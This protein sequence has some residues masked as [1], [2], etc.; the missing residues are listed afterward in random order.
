MRSMATWFGNESE[1]LTWFVDSSNVYKAK[2]PFNFECPMTPFQ[3][4]KQPSTDDF[5]GLQLTSSPTMDHKTEDF[6][7]MDQPGD[8]MDNPYV[9]DSLEDEF[10]RFSVTP[11]A[12]M[13]AIMLKQSR[14][15]GSPLTPPNSV[16]SHRKIHERDPKKIMQSSSIITA[17]SASSCPSNYGSAVNTPVLQEARHPAQDQILS[18]NFH[19]RDTLRKVELNNL[20]HAPVP[21]PKASTLDFKAQTSFKQE[22]WKTLHDLKLPNIDTQDW[23]WAPW[24]PFQFD[25]DTFPNRFDISPDGKTVQ[26]FKIPEPIDPRTL[27]NFVSVDEYNS[28]DREPLKLAR[29]WDFFSLSRKRKSDSVYDVKDHKDFLPRNLEKAQGF[30]AF[31]NSFPGMAFGLFANS[32][33]RLKRFKV[34]AS[35]RP[36]SEN[37][38]PPNEGYDISQT[39]ISPIELSPQPDLSHIQLIVTSCGV[40]PRR[41]IGHSLPGVKVVERDF[42]D[43]WISKDGIPIDG[44]IILSPQTCILLVTIE[45]IQQ[46]PLPGTLSVSKFRRKIAILT[47]KFETIYIFVKTKNASDRNVLLQCRASMEQEG[48][49]TDTVIH[50]EDFEENQEKVALYPR[51]ANLVK[52]EHIQ[53]LNLALCDEETDWEKYL[54][55]KMGVNAYAAQAIM[56]KSPAG[57][58]NGWGEP[59]STLRYL[60]KHIR[61]QDL[62]DILGEKSS[63]LLSKELSRFEEARIDVLLNN[64]NMYS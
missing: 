48:R 61:L 21:S 37:E 30:D 64:E 6:E 39:L 20:N 5:S 3:E 56:Q 8:A 23:A 43:S 52:Q 25:E 16:R 36:V 27:L 31:E 46:Q 42:T 60:Y 7:N 10:A 63:K 19:T 33:T 62:N 14:K 2:D 28:D 11:E 9:I 34:T 29:P 32:F 50:M 24:A 44:D 4:P 45:E 41:A 13:H 57:T 15:L 47:H 53:T 1:S 58:I 49:M 22:V 18:R 51:I 12:E 26:S 55:K 35:T 17:Q 59:L 40:M 38:Q 54:R